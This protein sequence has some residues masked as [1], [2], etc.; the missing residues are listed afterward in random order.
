MKIKGEVTMNLLKDKASILFGTL[1]Y[2][3]YFSQRKE[4]GRVQGLASSIRQLGVSDTGFI[5]H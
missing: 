3:N 2:E 5:T 1:A 4:K